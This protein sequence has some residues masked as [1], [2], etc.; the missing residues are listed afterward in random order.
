ME[1]IPWT[2]RKMNKYGLEQIKLEISLKT[3]TLL[4][5]K[6]TKLN[7]SY[8]GYITRRLG[9]LERIVLLGKNRRQQKKKKTKYEMDWLY[10]RSHRHESTRAE[11][12]C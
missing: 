2:A 8:F 9:S 4:E 10:K 12:G 1:Q 6:M 5:V 11:Q 7:L 3:E